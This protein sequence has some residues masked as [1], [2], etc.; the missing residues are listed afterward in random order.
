MKLNRRSFI[1]KSSALSMA[2][3]PAI[4][5]GS[6]YGFGS[7]PNSESI[8]SLEPTE[9]FKTYIRFMGSLQSETIYNWFSGHLWGIVPGE[10]PKPLTQFQGLAKSLW[11]PEG[12]T[13]TKQS[14]DLGFFSDLHSG[15]ILTEFKN[16]FTDKIVHP[17]HFMYGGGGKTIHTL[18]GIKSGET[19]EPYEMNWKECGD[20]VWMD[21]YKSIS[22]NNPLSPQEWKLSSAG[23]K[24]H[25]GTS[26]TYL[27][28]RNE[29]FNKNLMTSNQTFFWTTVNSW[30]PWLQMGQTPG[31]V[32]WRATGRKIFN[33][34]DIPNSMKDYVKDIQPNYFE[35]GKPWEKRRSTYA[36]Y[37]KDRKGEEN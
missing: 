13:Y 14:F 8:E 4:G 20:Q 28:N 29:L 1:E 5:I 19:V 32:M 7:I 36:S 18:H 22:F 9:K 33:V 35:A 21:Q 10:A 16:P 23:E 34:D 2:S 37:M 24:M 26:T 15:K 6:M 30:E 17:Y 27:G 11:E 12:D 31:Y 25:F 3:L